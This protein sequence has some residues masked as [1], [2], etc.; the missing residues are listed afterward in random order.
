MITIDASIAVKWFLAEPLSAAAVD[1]FTLGKKL[2]APDIL[3][4]EVT[5]AIAKAARMDRITADEAHLMITRWVSMLDSHAVS[6]IAAESVFAEA[7]QVCLDLR[8]PFHDCLYL[9]VARQL[10]VPLATTDKR[11]IEQ[12]AKSGIDLYPLG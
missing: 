11:L 6:L 2:L 3:R 1:L 7:V 4:L 5:A 10:K 12:A 9:A 8:H